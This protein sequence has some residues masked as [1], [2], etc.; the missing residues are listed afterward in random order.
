MEIH[1]TLCGHHLRPVSSQRLPK[2]QLIS[3]PRPAAYAVAA[4]LASKEP[5]DLKLAGSNATQ[6]TL[7]SAIQPSTAPA[8]DGIAMARA[9]AAAMSLEEIREITN[10]AFGY[11]L[12]KVSAL[13]TDH[14]CGPHSPVR[15]VMVPEDTA[16]RQ[17]TGGDRP[18]GAILVDCICY[19][20]F[21]TS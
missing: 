7:S 6:A 20:A 9:A 17:H 12:D 11:D 13:C 8:V 2:V 15:S 19:L 16:C 3:C 4:G 1:G 5:G 21:P 18:I 14:M 10:A